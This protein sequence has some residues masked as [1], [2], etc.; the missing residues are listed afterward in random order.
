MCLFLCVVIL[1]SVLSV[2]KVS[3]RQLRYTAAFFHFR[4]WDD[5]AS[6]GIR[7][8]WPVVED[9]R[10]KDPSPCMVYVHPVCVCHSLIGVWVL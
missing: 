10:P 7:T 6:K 8:R 5:Y 3:R 4:H 2:L 9:N 1:G